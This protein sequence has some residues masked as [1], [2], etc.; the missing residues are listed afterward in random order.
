MQYQTLI[1]EIG[2]DKVATVTIN[3]PQALNAFNAPMMREFEHVWGVL[4]A[5]DAVHAIVLRA[6]PGRAFSTGADVRARGADAPMDLDRPLEQRYPGEYLGPKSRHCW[7]P[8]IGAVH[9]LCCAGAFYWI[10]ECDFVLCSDDAQFFDPHVTYGMVAA[11]EPTALTYRIPYGEVMRMMLLGNDE[12]I[13]AHTALRIGLVTEIVEGHDAM[14]SRA[15]QLAQR[16]AQKPTL[17]VQGTVRSVWESQ[18]LPR[19]AALVQALKY[20]LFINSIS[21]A[22]I[23]R[24]AVMKSNKEFEVR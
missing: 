17:A 16:I 22:L 21:Q 4:Q 24:N 14:W 12:R 20:P 3:R 5:D 18:D 23:D 10:A 6:A 13:N 7:K 11:V 2:T 9:G 19:T 8:V 1:L 15:R